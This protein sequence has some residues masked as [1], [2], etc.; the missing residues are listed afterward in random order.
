MCWLDT[1]TS[2]E[3][4][5]MATLSSQ[6]RAISD[7]SSLRSNYQLHFVLLTLLPQSFIL[8][9]LWILKNSTMT[10]IC[11]FPFTLYLPNNSWTQVI[12]NGPLMTVAYFNLTIRDLYQTF[13][14]S[15]LRSSST[16]MTMFLLDIVGRTRP[17][18]FVENIYGLVSEPSFKISVNPVLLAKGP[19]HL[20]T[21]LTDFWSNSWYPRNPGIQFLW[22]SLNT[23][24]TLQA[25]PHSS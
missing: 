25:I 1:G 13:R 4:G 19:K 16:N 21:S 15:D 10:F 17:K 7:L 22:T 20:S 11:P 18:Q 3:K 23:Y 6:T 14:S 5:E 2:T 12:P 8:L 9:L 24:P